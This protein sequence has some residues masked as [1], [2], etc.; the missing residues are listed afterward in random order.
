VQPILTADLDDE[1]RDGRVQ[2]NVFVAGDVV[3]RQARGAEC[4]ELRADLRCQL[5]AR[6]G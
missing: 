2:M 4:R 5:A 6:G 3:E 1:P